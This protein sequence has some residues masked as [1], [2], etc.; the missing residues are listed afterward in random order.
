MTMQ[1]FQKQASAL[2]AAWLVLLAAAASGQD[3]RG[4]G[5]IQGSVVDA[6]GEPIAGATL[7]ANNP[8]RG[9]GTTIKSDAK[10]RWVLAGVVAGTWEIDV[11]AEGYEARRIAVTLPT[12]V[13]RLAPIKVPLD[14]ATPRGISDL[15]AAAAAADAAYKAG[16][17]AEARQEYEKLLAAQPDLAA[18]VE[19]QIGFTYI[20][21]KDF[22]K[23]MEHL[24]KALAKDPSNQKLRAVAAQAALEGGMTDR[25]KDLLAALDESAITSPDVFFNMGVNFFN[26]GASPEAIAYF[27]K[28]IRVDPAYVDAYYRRALAYLGQGQMAEARADFQKVV[29]LSPDGEMAAMARKALDQLK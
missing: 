4:Q 20:Q 8:E 5:R 28:A 24:D 25:A 26:R 23:A 18:L 21:E 29:E 16:R 11:A 6:Q 15:G 27:G 17:W 7:S 10:G 13:A 9:G 14:K 12:E 1:H 2:G 19:Q 22:T 3:W